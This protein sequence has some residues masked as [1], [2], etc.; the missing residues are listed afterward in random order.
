VGTTGKRDR[1]R[2]KLPCMLNDFGYGSCR[3]LTKFGI[4]GTTIK[5]VGGDE[6]LD[7][8]FRNIDEEIGPMRIVEYNN[9]EQS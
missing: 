8:K 7:K 4:V 2:A 1:E 6:I 9:I 5:Y 3:I